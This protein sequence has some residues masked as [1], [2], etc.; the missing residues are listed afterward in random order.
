MLETLYATG[1]RVTELTDLRMDA[2]RLEESLIHIPG[3]HMRL[4]PVGGQA[5]RALRAYLRSGRPHHVRPA[6][7]NHVFLNAQGGPLSRM[8]AWKIIK[9]AGE[10]AKLEKEVSPHTLRHSFATHL[11]EGGA[12]LRDV[13]ELLGHADISTTQIYTH[14]ARERMKDLHA[15]HHP[16]G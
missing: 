3:N 2:V 4:V 9:Q 15:R 7:G 10:K 12:N 8:S 13:Q 14:V 5:I 1:M 6:S 11:L 16:R